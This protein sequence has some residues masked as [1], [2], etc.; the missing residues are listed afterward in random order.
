LRAAELRRR[1][2]R[3]APAGGRRL[4][5]LLVGEREH[6]RLARL[7][8][9]GAVADE[10]ARHLALLVHLVELARLRLR[11]RLRPRARLPLRLALAPPLRPRLLLVARLRHPRRRRVHLLAGELLA[12]RAPRHL[13]REQPLPPRRVELR[14]HR[15]LLVALRL[16]RRQLGAAARRLGVALR[17]A[18]RRLGRER[19][20]AELGAHAV[21]LVD[22]RRDLA[23]GVGGLHGGAV[24]EE[25]ASRARWRPR[26]AAA[27][28]CSSSARRSRRA[29]GW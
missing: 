28:V 17:V 18:P 21:G 9:V 27:T 11:R 19:L 4:L 15:L 29:A 22:G 5:R 14:A 8:L 2:A 3:G 23:V 20:E 10:R 7:E 24:G 26:P 25:P 13:L 1:I 6:H 12:E 16:R